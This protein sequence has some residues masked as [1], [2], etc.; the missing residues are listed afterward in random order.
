MPYFSWGYER[1]SKR[2]LARRTAWLNHYLAKGCNER[3]ARE[4]A[5][6]KTRGTWPPR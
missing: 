5:R 2:E 3:K 6:R 1:P 4:C